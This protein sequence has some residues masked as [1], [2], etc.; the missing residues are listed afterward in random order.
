[1][2]KQPHKK[3]VV[4]SMGRDGSGALF[5]A[6]SITDGVEAR[7]VY[8]L[9]RAKVTKAM[10]RDEESVPAHIRESER[11]I[12]QELPRETVLYFITMVS[13]PFSRHLRQVFYQLRH[14][15]GID[16]LKL[17][18][19]S[20]EKTLAYFNAVPVTH[21]TGWFANEYFPATGIDVYKTH[22]DR[23]GGTVQFQVGPHHLLL[24]AEHLSATQKMSA[25]HQFL[26]IA[27][28]PVSEERNTHEILY[29]VFAGQILAQGMEAI[30]LTFWYS[31]YARHFFSIE[32]ISLF[33]QQAEAQK[34]KSDEAFAVYKNHPVF[35]SRDKLLQDAL[36][37]LMHVPHLVSALQID[38]KA[39]GTETTLQ[40]VNG[41]LQQLE[42]AQNNLL[43]ASMRAVAPKQAHAAVTMGETWLARKKD[44]RIVKSLA[45]YA[46]KVGAIT[47]PIELLNSLSAP[48]EKHRAQHIKLY[49]QQEFLENPYPFSE[50]RK[51]VAQP[52][53][54]RVLY[55][56]HQ[57]MPYHTSGYAT[58]TH[59]L[60]KGLA[61]CGWN[62]K[63]A[64]R[65]GY[66]LDTG[67][68][69]GSTLEE[70]IEGITY[71]YCPKEGYGQF[72]LPLKE[73]I[74]HAAEHLAQEAQK[75]KPGILHTASNF[76]CGM[77]GVEAAR[78]LGIPSI[79]EMRGLWHMTRWSKE[80]RYGDTD[81]FALAQKMELETALAADHVI[82]ITGAVK[83]WL[84]DHGIQDKNISVAPNAVDT[85]Q[86]RFIRK[87]EAYAAQIGCAGKIVIGYMGS[88]VEYE[89]LD[90]LVEAVSLLPEPLR[91]KIALLWVGDGPA[92]ASLLEHAQTLGVRE[93]ILAL[94][95]RPFQ[96]IPLLY[97]LVDICVFPRKGQMIC[98]I[99]SPLKP[100]EAMAM[101]KAIIVSDVRPLKEIVTHEMTG[102]IH[103]K[104]DPQSLA[105]QLQRFITEDR[106]REICGKAA[107]RWVEDTRTWKKIA[108]QVTPVY[109]M[110]WP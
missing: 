52:L 105:E 98:E 97:S 17:V 54:K 19:A 36:S 72:E 77:A 33:Q 3:V 31:A 57:A 38:I 62:V 90:L 82:A 15:V 75:W 68:T 48:D 95:R 64:T 78:R 29:E 104:D 32:Q 60:V 20:A 107:R 55:N 34:S 63:V 59:G 96:D 42:R 40:T 45:M 47:K 73:Y 74:H 39:R 35:M 13:D 22:F 109:E 84:I 51:S 93:T 85:E 5:D 61:D 86:F 66:P 6:L 70:T 106:L 21:T 10:L 49:S 11:I 101:E 24:L 99:V 58:R 110:L 37:P 88:F 108:E 41:V 67:I 80:P 30:A 69:P 81:H 71:S 8:T 12:T 1:M 7:R 56:A 92:M 102:L 4:Y 87:D 2:R 94:G 16:G 89:G 44:E 9:D 83:E 26:G 79:Y 28:K 76:M 46:Q 53:E 14:E 23:D 103:R 100:F 65:L 27:I 91:K 18:L 50:R 25:I 43:L